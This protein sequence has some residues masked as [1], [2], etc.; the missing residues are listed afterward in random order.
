MKEQK[1]K[2]T[3]REKQAHDLNTT[4]TGT[5]RGDARVVRFCIAVISGRGLIPGKYRGV[6]G[7]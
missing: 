4:M 7:R 5:V 1:N 3:T 2:Q 6:G